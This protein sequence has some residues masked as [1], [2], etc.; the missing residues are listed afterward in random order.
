M[1]TPGGRFAPSPT[2]PLH[3]GSLLAATASFLDARAQNIPW[4]LRIDDID[5]PRNVPGAADDIIRTLVAH[6]LHWDGPIV[7]QSQRSAHYEAAV[8]TLLNTSRIFYC[9]CSRR[10]LRGI[11][12]YP[13]TCRHMRD[14]APETALRVEVADARLRFDDNI[15]GRQ[16][17]YLFETVGDFIVKRRDGLIAYQLATAVDD[18]S[19]EI[20][21]VVRGSDLLDNTPRQLFLMELLNLEPPEYAHIPTLVSANGQKLSKQY[22]AAPV[23]AANAAKNLYQIFCLLGQNP[24]AESEFSSCEALLNWGIHN[25]S[26]DAIPAV[27]TLPTP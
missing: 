9:R 4:C 2:G 26:M 17:D 5:T 23:E 1:S 15:Q 12:V 13:G 25:W 8:H 11:T 14:P 7:W 24:P 21:Q 3:M 10:L 16:Q 19:D 22:H 6:D 20:T 18:G 27:K